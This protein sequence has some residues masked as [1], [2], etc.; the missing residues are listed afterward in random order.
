MR[1]MTLVFVGLLLAVGPIAPAA[2][3]VLPA[4]VT[5]SIAVM[6]GDVTLATARSRQQLLVTGDLGDGQVADLT[7]AVEFR[8]VDANV[9]A[10]DSKGVVTPKA[11][12]AT[13]IVVRHGTLEGRM[14]VTVGDV[15]AADPIDFRTESIAALS[16]SGCSQGACHGSP[17]GKN[18]F[19]LSLRGFDPSLDIVTLT[20]EAGTRRV[21][22]ISPNE[23]LLL[24]KGANR[25]PHQGGK[26]FATDEASYQTLLQWIAEGGSDSPVEK[27]LVKLEVLPGSRRLHSNHPA[28]RLVALAHFD[29]G[30]VR[31]VT[32][33]SDFSSNPDEAFD[34]ERDGV[35]R[36]HGTGEAVVLVRYLEK[37]SSVRLTYVKHD[38]AYV[39]HGPTPTNFVDEQILA[40]QKLLQ[41]QPADDAGDAAFMRRVYLDVIGALPTVDEA[42]AFLDS[43][44]ADKRARLINALLDRDEYAQFWAMK[45][46]DVMRGSR[47]TISERGVHSFHR[48]LV[49][50][51]AADRS[52]AEVA[53]EIV[54]GAGNTLH[55]P[56]ANFYRIA[57]TPEDAA[58]SMAQLFLGVRMQ[59]AR[60]HN[61]PFEAITQHDYYGL[62]AYFPR[63]K[64]KGKQFMLDDAVI[65][66]ARSGEINN[67][68]TKKPAEPTAFGVAAGPLG[69]DDDR[70]VKLAEWLTDKNNR[71][72]A[73]STVN[74]VWY[75]LLGTGL[76]EPVDDF[77]DSN[78][79]S[80]PEL[81]QALADEFVQ[82]GYRF[83][84]VMRAILN[85]RTYQLAA[86]QDGKSSPYAARAERYFVKAKIR[87]LTAEQILDG[88]SS[89][90]GLAEKFAGYP[91][92]TR[93]VELAEGAVENHFLTAFSKPIRDVQCD[94]AR[95]EEPSLNQVIHL[96]NN[97]G[98]VAKVGAADSRLGR[99]QAEKLALP[100][101]VE[102]V[103]LATLSRRPTANELKLV[104]DHAAALGDSSA[105]LQDL[106]HAL[107]NS[108]EF[109]LRH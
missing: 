96:L 23:S 70:R 94:C 92:G 22:L 93:A 77:R 67:P 69:P 10:V 73:A 7:D 11:A 108:N 35:V 54:T 86:Q 98:I 33:L 26:R 5:K 101:I 57:E 99:W 32:P 91:V 50:N 78:P 87:M 89:A 37:I 104:A 49:R 107:V 106:Q 42:R 3:S 24:R 51:L 45:W 36:F 75:H 81:L 31:D 48:Y 27:K 8:V 63:V 17:Q 82:S 59:C 66:L 53:R 1:L 90:T 58:E 109:L 19:R 84:P 28:Q 97:A 13:E 40:K 12:G 103:Y 18:G 52:W 39:Y 95:E 47:E 4:A 21:D 30:T 46:A 29:D 105:A 43:K 74:R 100:E 61:H 102:R 55:R 14:S 6:P 83:R 34:V 76:V 64:N 20:R 71:F 2:E 88:V 44:A 79:A 9:A 80:H 41:L 25:T 65:Y 15:T 62:A 16:R 85:S 38:P 72:F 68:Q 56:E 60:C